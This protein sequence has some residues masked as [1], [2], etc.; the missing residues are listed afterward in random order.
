MEFNEDKKSCFSASS[1]TIEASEMMDGRHHLFLSFGIFLILF[2]GIDGQ[3]NMGNAP[4][5][6]VINQLTNT[7]NELKAQ[8]QDFQ[9]R[10]RIPI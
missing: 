6:E 3:E 4:E 10:L 9:V 5:I 8:F 1:I 2:N 7:V